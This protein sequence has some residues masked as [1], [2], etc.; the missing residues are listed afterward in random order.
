MAAVDSHAYENASFKL[1][2]ILDYG[3]FRSL[4]DALF[5]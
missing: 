2:A 1:E 5:V 3:A 4:K